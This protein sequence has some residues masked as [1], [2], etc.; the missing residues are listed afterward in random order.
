MRQPLVHEVR[1]APPGLDLLILVLEPGADGMMGFVRL[2][3]EVGDRELKREARGREPLGLAAPARVG[4]RGS[5]K[6]QRSGREHQLGLL[7]DG[8]RKDRMAL[9]LARPERCHGLYASTLRRR[10]PTDIRVGGCSLRQDEPDELAPTGDVG[11]VH[12][13]LPLADEKRF[14]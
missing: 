13:G 1:R 14:R 5:D 9:P 4:S 11:P 7:Q 3:R 6:S 10:P 8:R 2:H 12:R